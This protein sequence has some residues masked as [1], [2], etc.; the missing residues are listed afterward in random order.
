MTPLI[1]VALVLVVMLLLISPLAFESAIGLRAAD[2]SAHQGEEQEPTEL[3]ELAIVSEDSVRVN[4]ML[5]ARDALVETVR[6]LLPPGEGR[7]IVTCDM[8]VSHGAFVDV[9]DRA[10]LAGAVEIGVIEQ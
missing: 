3:V 2:S 5:V 10:K 8:G 1:D 7:V 9:L 4:R 6:P